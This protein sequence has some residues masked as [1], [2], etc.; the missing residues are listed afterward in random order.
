[1]FHVE[2]NSSTAKFWLDSVRVAHRTDT[3]SWSSGMSTSEYDPRIAARDVSFAGERMTVELADG[4][5]IGLI[6]GR[7]SAEY[8]RAR[9][10]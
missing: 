5:T 4:R 7:P 1:M 2:R 9:S 6:E 10:G 3:R 8:L